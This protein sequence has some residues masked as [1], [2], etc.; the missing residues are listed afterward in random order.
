MLHKVLQSFGLNAANFG[1]LY[2]QLPMSKPIAAT[3]RQE[4][5]SA[6]CGK[7]SEIPS[8]SWRRSLPD[9]CPAPEQENLEKLAAE[10][11]LQP[12]NSLVVGALGRSTDCPTIATVLNQSQPRSF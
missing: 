11:G 3:C 8:S 4:S 10:A 6:R 7:S 2:I 9:N 12:S 1:A 5:P